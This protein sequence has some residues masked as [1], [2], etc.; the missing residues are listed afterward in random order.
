ME[1]ETPLFEEI[2][3]SF[4]ILSWINP[5]YSAV[6]LSVRSLERMS[7]SALSPKTMHIKI[8]TSHFT[9]FYL[10]QFE[11]TYLCFSNLRPTTDPQRQ[12]L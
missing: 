6:R 1:T 12:G 5:M 4:P 11:I 7:L 10:S 8:Y 2:A 9:F 3:P